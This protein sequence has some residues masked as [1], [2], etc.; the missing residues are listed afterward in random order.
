MHLQNEIDSKDSSLKA[1]NLTELTYQATQRNLKK[2]QRNFK[3]LQ[4]MFRNSSPKPTKLPKELLK[5]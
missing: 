4:E 1:T 5:K 2:F 3:K